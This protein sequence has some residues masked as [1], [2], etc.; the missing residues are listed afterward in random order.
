MGLFDRN[1][2]KSGTPR[3]EDST[4]PA[5]RVD[6]SDDDL[7][8]A[9]DSV[10]GI[11]VPEATRPLAVPGADGGTSRETRDVPVTDDAREQNAPETPSTPEAPEA[12]AVTDATEHTD[13]VGSAD[14][15]EAKPK[16]DI[17]AMSGRARPQRI[18]PRTAEPTGTPAGTPASSDGDRT[19]V[20]GAA[21]ADPAYGV[22][23]EEEQHETRAFGSSVGAS[24]VADP[25]Y[26]DGSSTFAE[27]SGTGQDAPETSVFAA[28]ATGA[29]TAATTPVAAGPTTD[30]RTVVS[31][32]DPESADAAVDR[33]PRAGDMDADPR[34]GTLD[35]GLF[36]LRVVVGA[37]LVVRG[38]QTLF[39]FGGDPGIS[40]FEQTLAAY[41]FADI[42]AVAVPVARSWLEDFWSS[43]FS[44]RW[45]ALSQWLS[46]ASSRC[47]TC[48][49]G[50][51]GTGRTLSVP[52]CSSGRFSASQVLS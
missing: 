31:P 32:D 20:F 18:E 42:L 5:G 7:F 46:Q 39:A 30:D 21:A 49:S 45:E 48:R 41:N 33:A 10:D 44:R 27:D 25:A 34:R 13:G 38:L 28:G 43:A 24:G 26:A 15:G 11:D 1:P 23:G 47:T 9:I 22:P 37:L 29:G 3:S 19:E 52:R 6:H 17:Y 12:T 2:E 8:D 50:I 14:A 51:R 40:A 36:I 16:R 35:F 4:T